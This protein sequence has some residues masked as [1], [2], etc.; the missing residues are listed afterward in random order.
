MS[1][2]IRFLITIIFLYSTSKSQNIPQEFQKYQIRKLLYNAGIG[3]EDITCLGSPRFQELDDQKNYDNVLYSDISIGFRG[4]NKYKTIYFFTHFKYKN[5]L[6]GYLYP[7]IVNNIYAFDRYS[8]IEMDR[9]RSGFKSGETDLSGIGYQN[10]WLTFQIGRGRE[11]WGAGNDIQLAL[12]RNSAPY[13]YL[14]LASDYGKIRVK[15]IHGFLETNSDNINRYLTAR[16]LEWTNRKNF[17]F[18]I[19]E[20]VVYS[21]LNRPLD[22]SYLNPI[23]THLEVELNNRLN[24]IGYDGSNAVWQL[25]IDWFL[26]SNIRLSTNILFDEFVIDRIELDAGKEHGKAYSLKS[27]FTPLK[28]KNNIITFY[29]SYINIGTPTFRHGIGSN[30]FVQRSKPLGWEYGSDTEEYHFGINY[31][32]LNKI[33]IETEMGKRDLGEES[34][35][36]KPYQKYKDYIKGSFPSGSIENT[37]FFT[38]KFQCWPKENISG[39]LKFELIKIEESLYE[40]YFYI[41]FDIAFGKSLEI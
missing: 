37:S 14:L 23:S 39:I 20:T 4:L 30:N 15:Y 31:L 24:S 35:T 18:S 28:T 40:K 17:L 10:N 21:G 6:Y 22:L 1:F 32:F 36:S 8:G 34:I 26:K 38:S 2:K 13:D 7:R 9:S 5:F 19:S 16:G 12:S 29:C 27:A 25:S 3:W 33:I 11:S 41:G